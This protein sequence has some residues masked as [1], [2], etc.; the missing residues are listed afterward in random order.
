[1]SSYY[2]LPA[3]LNFKKVET[4]PVDTKHALLQS[5]NGVEAAT[6]IQNLNIALYADDTE[7]P[8]NITATV[9]QILAQDPDVNYDPDTGGDPNAPLV[10]AYRVHVNGWTN[11]AAATTPAASIL[12][13]G[14]FPRSTT[15]NQLVNILK[16]S[17]VLPQG[18][19]TAFVET[20]PGEVVDPNVF[21]IGD[22]PV[23]FDETD[24]IPTWTVPITPPYPEL[25]NAF[26]EF[27]FSFNLFTQ[28]QFLYA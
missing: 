6:K 23:E 27:D 16:A 9:S 10:P 28:P 3:N 20:V 1:M 14:G 18:T 25:T 7:V 8:S 2:L 5:F 21:I 17:V 11:V 22:I 4:I 26:L 15:S 12:I 13:A 24:N 19:M